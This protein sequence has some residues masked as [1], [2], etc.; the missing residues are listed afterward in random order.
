MWS[1]ILKGQKTIRSNTNFREIFY[2]PT[3]STKTTATNIS[4]RER[5]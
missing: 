5:H 4:K 3:S 2:T 1:F